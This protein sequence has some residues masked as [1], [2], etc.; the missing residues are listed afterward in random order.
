MRKN[1]T[2][3]IINRERK[4]IVFGAVLLLFLWGVR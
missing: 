4:F 1:K 3:K 2:G